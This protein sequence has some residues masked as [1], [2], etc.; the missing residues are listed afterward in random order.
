MVWITGGA[1]DLAR[2]LSAEFTASGWRVLA[3]PRA[4]LD[5]ADRAGGAAWMATAD[6][7]CDLLVHNAGVRLDRGL[8]G[9]TEA[10]WQQ[11]IDV[12]LSAVHRLSRAVVGRWRQAGRPGHLV[13]IGSHSG[14]H[15]VAGQAN[16]AAAK[17]GLCGL[18]KALAA[19]LGP[20]DIRVNVVLPGFLETRMTRDLS[21][22]DRRRHLERHALGRFNRVEDAA[23]FIAYLHGMRQVSGQVFQLDSRI[24]RWA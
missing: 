9:L 7:L 19:E 20:E 17:A 24:D 6:P 18:A 8:P 16:Y 3:P 13:F 5:V 10:D 23:R 21:P 2:A 11:V 15:G 1:G 12:N 22:R 14:S 4:E